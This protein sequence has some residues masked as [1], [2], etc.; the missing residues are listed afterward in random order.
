[1]RKINKIIIHCSD[2]DH[3]IH[4]NI[5]CIR[6]WH[7][8]KGWKDIGYHFVITKNGAIWTGRPLAEIGAHCH[9]YNNESIGICLTGKNSFSSEQFKSLREL[10][11]SLVSMFNC[12]II[13]HNKLSKYKTCPNFTYS[14]VI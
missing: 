1:M 13:E 3:K 11:E 8:K 10:C 7:K 5:D 12:D 2:S 9:G 6:F 4:D 14:E